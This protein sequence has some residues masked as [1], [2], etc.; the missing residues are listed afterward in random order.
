MNAVSKE[1]ETIISEYVHE[2]KTEMNRMSKE[3]SLSAPSDKLADKEIQRFNDDY[4]GMS[5]EA[6]K[7]LTLS[8]SDCA[9]Y[10]EMTETKPHL[11]NQALENENQEQEEQ[12]TSRSHPHLCGSCRGD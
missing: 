2:Q 11:F 8:T 7:H 6:P 12:S 1:G 4:T 3:I 10:M 9:P 5:S